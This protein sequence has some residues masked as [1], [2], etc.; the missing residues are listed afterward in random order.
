MEPPTPLVATL[1][2]RVA[3][4]GICED[5]GGNVLLVR[6]ARYLTV[7]GQWF[8]PGGG[9]GHGEDPVAALRREFTEE[10]GLEVEVGA[11]KGVLSDVITL[12]NGTILHTVSIIHGIDSFTGVLRDEA[13]GSSDAARWQPLDRAQELPL[14]PYVHRALT[15]LR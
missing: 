11:L 7:A 4:Y 5:P 3:V 8:L 9:I 12:P 2:Q 14:A 15:E 1:E 6:A 10:T 13:E